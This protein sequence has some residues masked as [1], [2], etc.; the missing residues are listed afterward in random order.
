MKFFLFLLS[1]CSFF[2]GMTSEAHASR[3]ACVADVFSKQYQHYSEHF[4]GTKREWTCVYSCT[5]PQGE[6]QF[7]GSHKELSLGKDDG[8]EGI[9]DGVPVISTYNNFVGGFIWI[10][11]DA[12]DFDP[13]DSS[14]NNLKTWAKETCR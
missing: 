9:C 4:W 11:Q 10:P 12:I 14:A 1:F 2:L 5:T 6:V 8:R 3:C 7:T 13:I